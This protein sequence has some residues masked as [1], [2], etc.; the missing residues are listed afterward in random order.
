MSRVDA[1]PDELEPPP[2]AYTPSADIRHGEATVELGPRRPFQ[3]AP[4]PFLT[5]QPT[6]ISQI[7]NL[8]VPQRTGQQSTSSL[9]DYPGRA[10]RAT[11]SLSSAASRRTNFQPP[12]RH[13][14]SVSPPASPPASPSASQAL[15]RHSTG[16]S[17]RPLSDFARDFYGADGAN[18]EETVRASSESASYQ[19]PSSLP[20]RSPV[21]SS[22]GEFGSNRTFVPPADPPPGPA[23][24]ASS[25][26]VANY[27]PTSSPTPG[28]P[29]LNRGRA[30][31]YPKNH[32]CLKCVS[33]STCIDYLSTHFMSLAGRN[34]GY[35]NN[36]PSHPCQKVFT[37]TSWLNN[38]IC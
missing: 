36:D 35:K 31:V 15:N 10:S 27:T 26:T 33:F 24:S 5:P 21:R 4:A 14:S 30:L 3:P 16:S 25:Q 8:Q 9:G 12:P 38:L 18:P 2:P 29:L 28:R 34:T 20:P 22:N 7:Q 19:P 32:T 1:F 11:A 13:P 17:Q 23:T 6:G 37:S